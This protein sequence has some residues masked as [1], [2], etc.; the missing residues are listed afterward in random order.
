MIDLSSAKI[1]SW[2][3]MAVE[4]SAHASIFLDNEIFVAGGQSKKGFHSSMEKYEN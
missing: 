2:P 1:C 3:A 4:R